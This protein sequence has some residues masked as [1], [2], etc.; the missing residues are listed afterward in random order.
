MGECVRGVY[1]PRNPGKTGFYRL[2]WGHYEEFERA[3]PERYERVF[4]YFRPVI[5]DVVRRYLACG[6]LRRG[7]ARVRCPDCGHEYLLAFSCKGRYF[8]TSCHTRRAVLFSG[9]LNEEVLW[10]VPHRQVVLTVPKMLRP[11]FRYDR[12]LLGELCR[13]AASVIT[14]S[15][16]HLLDDA[17]LDVGVVAC[18]HTFG[19]FVNFHPH[20]HALVTDGG[21]TPGG[22]FH[23]LPKVSLAGMEQLF[24][25]RVLRMLLDRGKIRPERVR[26]LLSWRHSGFNL[27]ASVRV[28]AG[29]ARGRETIAQYLIRAPF[30]VGKVR[31][32]PNKGTVIYKTKMVK[33]M[34]RD[35]G[36]YNSLDFLAAVT[37]HIPNRREHM[38]RYYGWYS[39]VR[40]GRRR[41]A[42]LEKPGLESVEVVDD[43]AAGKGKNRSWARLIRKVF[44]VDPLLCPDCGGEMRIISF[45]EELAVVRKI[46][47]HLGL[48]EDQEPRPPPSEEAEAVQE[49]EY[50]PCLD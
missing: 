19:N 3:Y 41:K 7:F 34:N 22:T 15:I 17:S 16:R 30:S 42:G 35:F 50:V 21:F 40:R 5:G 18:V 8:C 39:S 6:D 48:W 28:G 1:R 10:P 25:H 2:V 33:G 47:E 9:W 13:V 45:I 23:V 24:R 44:E 20:I 4:G 46:L 14:E 32:F 27:D 29:D 26:M 43:Q 36:I 37:A 12:T 49:L 31:Y 38:V 11:Y